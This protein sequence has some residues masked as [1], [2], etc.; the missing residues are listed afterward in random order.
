M[1]YIQNQYFLSS[2]AVL[3][4]YP[5]ITYRTKFYAGHLYGSNSIFSQAPPNISGSACRFTPSEA[6]GWNPDNFSSFPFKKTIKYMQAKYISHWGGTQKICLPFQ[7][8][9]ST[10]FRSFSKKKVSDNCFMVKTKSY[11][12]YRYR[13][14]YLKKT[15]ISCLSSSSMNFSSNFFNI[16]EKKTQ[17]KHSINLTKELP[18][19]NTYNRIMYRREW[20]SK[21]CLKRQVSVKNSLKGVLL[22]NFPEKEKNFLIKNL[23]AENKIPLITQSAS[24]LLKDSRNMDDLLGVDDPIQVL[25]DKVKASEPCICVRAVQNILFRIINSKTLA[26]KQSY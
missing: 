16:G 5:K 1:S 17:E 14:F 6:M 18:Y 23:A 13:H 11:K 9:L 2:W 24:L 3:S 21:L 19:T 10:N 8:F 22:V 12:P 20:N 25:F 7:W 15:S 4:H 26:W